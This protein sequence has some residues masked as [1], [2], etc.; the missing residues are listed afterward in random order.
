L[1]SY[2]TISSEGVLLLGGSGTTVSP[3]SPCAFSI[4]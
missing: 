1:G 2:L 4:L 3:F